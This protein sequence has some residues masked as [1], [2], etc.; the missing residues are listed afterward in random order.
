MKLS[1][2]TNTDR[3]EFMRSYQIKDMETLK[4]ILAGNPLNFVNLRHPYDRLV[5][6]FTMHEKH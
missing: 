4:Y 5:S 3:L 2:K 6:D 1:N